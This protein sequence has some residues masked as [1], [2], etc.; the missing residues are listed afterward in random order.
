M[1][2][3]ILTLGQILAAQARL[4]PER[5]AVRDLERAM[6]FRVWNERACRLANA[7]LG[8]GLRPGDRVAVLAYNCVEW[9]EIYAGTA[10]AGI[11][12]VPINFR[13]V[14]QEARYIIEDAG[15]SA[16]IVQDELAGLV[17]EIRSDLPFP[18]SRMVRFGAARSSAGFTDYETLLAA[19]ATVESDSGVT[20][21]D[22][23]MLM[24]T[25]GTTGNPKGAIR[26]HR[27]N[28]LVSLITE[29]ELGIKRDDNAL[30]VMPMCHAN[31][32]YF[33]GAYAY[34]G[35]GVTIYSRKSFDPEHALKTLADV[36]ATFTSLVPTHYIMM[37]ALSAEMRARHPCDAVR[38]LMISSAPARPDTKRAIMEMFR[39]S[40][41]YELYG[42]TEAA[43]VTMLHPSEQ[44]T[45]LGSVGR[46]CVGSAPIRLLDEEGNE[47]PDGETGE[48]FSSN[49]Y[50]FDGYWNLPEKTAEAFRGPYCSVGDMAR[51]DEDGYIWLVDRKKNMI[52]SGGENVYPSEVEIAV[53][54]HA[55]VKDVAVIGLP[56]DKWGER[57]HAVIILHEGMQASEADIMEHARE[58]LAGYKRPRTISFIDED[59]MPRTATGKIL[60]RILR[61]RL[62]AGS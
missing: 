3:D 29:I 10:K 8:L 27:A 24:Y 49:P 57:V 54:S 48:L 36:G 52:I 58:R 50:T 28:A 12:A 31:S 55:A 46:E 11:V 51:R 13:L 30:L 32:L 19:A 4:N 59:G 42:S 6:S 23:W 40:G 47:V 7:L 2:Q 33:F 60:H 16:L 14:A 43:W 15:A 45:K 20:A 53:G 34:C 22:P 21:S 9:A 38:Q 1:G 17:E 18:A 35:A 37:L 61:Q 26:S 39:N 25:S 44:F 56:D 5:V 62:G 41:L